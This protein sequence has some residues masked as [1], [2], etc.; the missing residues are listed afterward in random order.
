EAREVSSEQ[1]RA[2]FDDLAKAS[3]RALDVVRANAHYAGYMKRQ[4]SEINARGKDEAV[5]IG[6]RFD[7]RTVGGLSAELLEKLERSRPR[8][9]GAASRIEGMTPA[10]LGALFGALR[11]AD[12]AAA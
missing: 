9:L 7:Y 8:S 2:A 4:E 1:L 5:R 3:A 6:E 12:R 11:K 10:A